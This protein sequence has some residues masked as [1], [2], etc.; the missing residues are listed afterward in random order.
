MCN[1]SWKKR[2]KCSKS[3]VL[4]CETSRRAEVIPAV[5]KPRP[6]HH[7]LV[8][9]A[10]DVRDVEAAVEVTHDGL[11]AEHRLASEQFSEDLDALLLDF[12]SIVQTKK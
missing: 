2:T 12:Q 11:P 1:E 9:N 3:Q 4:T 7:N 10:E 5:V 6:R 8:A